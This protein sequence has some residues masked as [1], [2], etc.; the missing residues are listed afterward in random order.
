MTK[1]YTKEEEINNTREELADHKTILQ[2]A[3]KDLDEARKWVQKVE[4]WVLEDEEKLSGLG[5]NDTII[6]PDE[7]D[8]DHDCKGDKCTHPSHGEA[9]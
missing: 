7:K 5:Y 2:I 1:P 8:K 4:R 3:F 9:V 6:Y